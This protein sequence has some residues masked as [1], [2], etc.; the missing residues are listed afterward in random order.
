MVSYFALV[1]IQINHDTSDEALVNSQQDL[2]YCA[3]YRLL[4]TRVLTVLCG[5]G[6]K[7]GGNFSCSG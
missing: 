7:E 4:E 6:I 2:V 5:Q 3:N 1:F